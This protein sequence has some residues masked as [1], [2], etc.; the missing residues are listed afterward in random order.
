M[1]S[2][3]LVEYIWEI[4]PTLISARK[5]GTNSGYILII[6]NYLTKHPKFSGLKQQL[7][8]LLKNM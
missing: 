8:M 2:F 5:T 3:Q 1:L 7:F 6:Y 4:K